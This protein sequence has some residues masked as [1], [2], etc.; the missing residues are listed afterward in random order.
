M[1]ILNFGTVDPD[2]EPRE[3]LAELSKLLNF[4]LNGKIDFQNIRARSIKAENIETGTLTANEIAANTITADKMNVDELSAITANLG[5]MIAGIIRGIQIFGSY[6]ATAEG[7]YPRS[8]MSATDDLFA[9]Y[10]GP[11]FWIRMSPFIGSP[12]LQ[13]K[14][15]TN[16]A[17]I[18]YLGGIFGITSADVLRL[19]TTNEL[20]LNSSSIKVN[21]N[22]AYSGTVTTDTNTL[23]FENGL[24]ISVS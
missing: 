1:P 17:G 14:D 6:I 11:D 23:T 24:L 8:E 2:E 19:N 3:Q 7:T 9:V 13:F 20:L 16:V 5:T 22:T 18:N 10:A 12:A 15:G 21:G 4:L